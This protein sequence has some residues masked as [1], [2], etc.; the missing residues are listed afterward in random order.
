ME[1]DDDQGIGDKFNSPEAI[2]TE[3]R[4]V[5]NQLKMLHFTLKGNHDGDSGEYSSFDVKNMEIST[6]ITKS[7]FDNKNRPPFRSIPRLN[8]SNLNESIRIKRG[9]TPGHAVCTYR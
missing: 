6:K 4:A 2:M 3:A 7:T 5:Y 8:R 9:T 1:C